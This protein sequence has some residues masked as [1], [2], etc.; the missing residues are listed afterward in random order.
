M[1]TAE[2]HYLPRADRLLTAGERFQDLRDELRNEITNGLD[3][4]VDFVT[5]GPFGGN[6][7]VRTQTVPDAID[8]A[9]D[10][11]EVEDAFREMLDGSRCL[12]VAA[13]R[14]RIATIVFS[15]INM[16]V[17]DTLTNPGVRS[18]LLQILRG[19][20]DHKVIALRDAIIASY[21][22]FQAERVAEAR[23]L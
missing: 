21:V 5:C 7:G 1:G 23:G 17:F 15:Q 8:T 10:D 9:L 20:R 11:H 19:K 18:C 16:T 13:L 3:G 6:K 4:R 12:M 22:E 14:Q 2:L